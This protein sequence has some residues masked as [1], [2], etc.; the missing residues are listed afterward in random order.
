MPV[1][2]L[3]AR[4]FEIPPDIIKIRFSIYFNI[5]I[6]FSILIPV[7]SKTFQTHNLLNYSYH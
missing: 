2:R 5:F 3:M 1:S 7:L 6:S 4:S